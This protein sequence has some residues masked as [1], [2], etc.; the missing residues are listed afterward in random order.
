MMQ[1][2]AIRNWSFDSLSIVRTLYEAATK[3]GT[4]YSRTR[5]T[6]IA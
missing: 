4:T 1:A 2:A 5:G 3:S 6:A